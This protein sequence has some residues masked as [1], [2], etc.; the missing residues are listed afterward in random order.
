MPSASLLAPRP[1]CIP[2]SWKYRSELVGVAAIAFF[3][4]RSRAVSGSS[5]AGTPIARRTLLRGAYTD[6]AGVR[7]QRKRGRGIETSR[8]QHGDHGDTRRDNSPG[9]HHSLPGNQQ[10]PMEQ[11]TTAS[12]G[13]GGKQG[14]FIGKREQRFEIGL[15]R[16]FVS[17]T[18]SWSTTSSRDDWTREMSHHI[19]GLNQNAARIASSRSTQAQSRRRTCHNSCA[20]T[21]R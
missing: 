7:L 6:E 19:A 13:C 15:R 12:E 8:Q 17:C 11:V 16:A 14:R 3:S 2:A 21:A 1:S 10:H 9:R 18:V 20:S 5:F 4:S